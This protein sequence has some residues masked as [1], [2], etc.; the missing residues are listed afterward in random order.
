MCA[1]T[2]LL[3]E[4]MG[5][6]RLEAADLPVP[7]PFSLEKGSGDCFTQNSGAG[8]PLRG[9]RNDGWSGGGELLVGVKVLSP[10]PF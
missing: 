3:N 9:I 2:V 5:G 1:S 4:Y 7:P 10:Q 8:T 6:Q